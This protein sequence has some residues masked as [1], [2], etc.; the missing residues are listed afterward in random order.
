MASI[1]I[2][3]PYCRQA[4]Y[5]CNFHFSTSLQTKS[6]LLDALH[7]ELIHRKN[8]LSGEKISTIYF[9]GGTPSLLEV[10]E[11][12][13]IIETIDRNY[14]LEWDKMEITLEANPDDLKKEKIQD[15]YS[16]GINRLSIGVQ[17][18]FDTDLK[19]LHRIH[20]AEQS[21]QCIQEA[22]QSGFDNITIDLIYGVQNQSDDIWMQNLETLKNY[23]LP[24][25]SAY[26]LTIEPKTAF[27]KM[28]RQGKITGTDDDQAARQFLVLQQWAN[29]QN[30]LAYEI[31]N[32]CKP[33]HFSKHNTG[34]WLGEKYLG[35]GPSAHS[36]NTH[37]RQWNIAN[38]TKYIQS[39]KNNDP[40]Y[41][42]E[43][44]S[45]ISQYNE[46]VM[47]SLRTMWGCDI[48]LIRD[49]FGLAFANEITKSSLRYVSDNLLFKKDHKLLLTL[50]GKLLADNII[51]GL[52]I[53]NDNDL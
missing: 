4:C 24:H 13:K 3:I 43:T 23:N 2:H 17:S 10:D 50:A 22:Q 31:S 52:F 19:T 16:A 18:F 37:S 33:G 42:M 48:S 34:Y 6:E 39:V 32:Y 49:R 20:N 38:N 40:Y 35:A 51:S 44:L 25:F 27:E 26:A 14:N 9:G 30:Y 41:E 46:Y 7:L 8:Y 29:E 15:L 5:Y 28:I 11:I 36:F 45:D 53:L 47:T 21:H 1:Y 12:K